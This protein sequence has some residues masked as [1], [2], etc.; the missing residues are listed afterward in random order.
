M[1]GPGQA[2]ALCSVSTKRIKDEEEERK[3]RLTKVSSSNVRKNK[4]L[5]TI[6]KFWVG[7]GQK[8]PAK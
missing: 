6:T 5:K 4:T 7:S 3:N 1:I 2:S 8:T